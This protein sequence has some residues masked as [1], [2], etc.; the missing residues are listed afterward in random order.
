MTMPSEAAK[1]ARTDGGGKGAC[2]GWLGGNC[3][4]GDS[5]KFEHDPSAKG[6]LLSCAII[7]ATSELT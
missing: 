2:K 5:C 7:P 4:F 6:S 1:K 3:R